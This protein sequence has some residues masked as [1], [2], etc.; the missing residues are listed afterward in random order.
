MAPRTLLLLIIAAQRATALL[1]TSPA[2]N[3][4]LDDAFPRALSYTLAATG[5]T[6]AGALTGW[7]FHLSLSLNGGQ[8]TCGEAGISTTYTP[9]PPSA[10]G[11]AT[12]AACALN[13]GAGAPAAL[14]LSLTGS[15]A[16]GADP[17]APGAAAFTLVLG[18]AALTGPGAPALT[19]LDVAGLEL[20][21]LRPPANVSA[22]MY[23]PTDS[24]RVPRCAGDFYF[25][26]SWVNDGLDEWQAFTFDQTWVVGQVDVNTPAGGNQACMDGAAS[27]HGPGPLASV[28]AGGWSASAR[29]GAAAL[30]SEHHAPFRTGLRAHDA[31]GRCSVFSIAPAPL[32][33]AYACG[34]G[35]PVTL[36]VGVFGDLTGDGAV[37]GDDLALWRRAQF[38]RADVLYRT[39]L[40]YKIQID[41]TAYNPSWSRLPFAAVLEYVRNISR[42]TDAYPQTPILV[43]W[44]GLG[45]DT[46]YPGLDQINLHPDVGGAAGLAALYAG[47]AAAS[48]SNASSLSFHVNSDEAYS[49]FN[50][51]P[52]PAFDVGSVRLNVDHATPW[53][54]DCAVAG[55]T[56]NCGARCSLS[57]AKDAAAHG[58]YAR[59]QRFF[60]AIQPQ[61]L[62]TI[63]SDAWR[64]VGASWEPAAGE[65]S[66]YLD[67]ANEARC[68]QQADAAFWAAHGA[69]MGGE[70]NDGQASE[71]MGEMD[72]L[73]HGGSQWDVATWGRIVSGGAL[74]WDLDVTCE[75]PGGRCTWDS[76]ADQFWGAAA[77]YQLALT[78]ELLGTS[79][80]GWHVFGGGG[81]VHSSHT[82]PAAAAA[83]RLG[84]RAVPHPS[85]WPFG[86]D[87][88][89]IVNGHGGVLL[90]RVLPDGTTLAPNTLHAY[91]DSA[92][93]G[94]PY[95][96]ACPLFHPATA[97]AGADNTA[98]GNYGAADAWV[99]YEA[100]LPSLAAAQRCNA[101][102]YALSNCSAWDLIKVTPSSGRTKPTCGLFTATRPVGCRA[103]SNQW[104]GAKAPLPLPPAPDATTQTWTLPLAWVG[105]ALTAT[106]LTPQGPQAGLV[107]V[108]VQGRNLTLVGMTPSWAVR[109]EAAQ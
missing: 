59:L 27:R 105:R 94:P 96:P 21:S 87:A 22:C 67:F 52:N 56:P 28:F 26:D 89:P 6:L 16:A 9:A 4:T 64:D 31:P 80:G 53:C 12:T 71:F 85:T 14:Q 8:V 86:G 2:L 90:P 77:V 79:A 11:F 46:L 76:M 15:V 95:D 33:L 68:G 38:P 50:S 102:C 104:A 88:I 57:K 106:S 100:A 3:V 10:A 41:L 83:A 35:L 29:T 70:G 101:S 63:H 93:A 39:T 42:I 34:T 108:L 73:Y 48:G 24:G 45:H 49:H 23:T 54:M 92:G 1:L 69:S 103:D 7:G 13:W 99:E 60:D 20:L 51:L 17:A 91:Q 109:I 65:G 43:G 66:G 40:P 36:T 72:F 37:S 82:G 97:A 44:Q 75:N 5:E 61:G 25:V 58:R 30:S 107:Q 32:H 81:R 78:Q 84:A 47:L 18:G 62:R 74:G 55:Q 98:L 19:T